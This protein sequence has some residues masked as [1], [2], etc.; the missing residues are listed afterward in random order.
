M[1]VGRVLDVDADLG[2]RED[3]LAGE[4]VAAHDRKAERPDGGHDGVLFRACGEVDDEGVGIDAE[5]DLEVGLGGSG[6]GFGDRRFDRGDLLRGIARWGGADSL[7]TARDRNA[8]HERVHTY[9]C[10]DQAACKR[11]LCH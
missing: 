11:W 9:E 1:G 4:H 7:H 6:L 8:D 2:E 5:L 3:V 10:G